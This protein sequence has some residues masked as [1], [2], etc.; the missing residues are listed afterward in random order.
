M[1]PIRGNFF[2]IDRNQNILDAG[3]HNHRQRFWIEIRIKGKT[4][5]SGLGNLHVTGKDAKGYHCFIRTYNNQKF[6]GIF[7][8]TNRGIVSGNLEIQLF[9]MS[10]DQFLQ[11]AMDIM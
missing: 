1:K 8:A 11:A 7:K 5:Y 2:S 6:Q 9:R 3:L 10:V 4:I